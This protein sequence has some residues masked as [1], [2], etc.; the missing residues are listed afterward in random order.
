MEGHG[1]MVGSAVGAGASFMNRR[2]SG[3]LTYQL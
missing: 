2:S 3:K 1:Q